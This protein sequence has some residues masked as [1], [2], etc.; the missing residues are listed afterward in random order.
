MSKLLLIIGLK[1]LKNLLIRIKGLEGNS[2]VTIEWNL[3]GLKRRRGAGIT[4]TEGSHN[5]SSK[6]GDPHLRHGANQLRSLN[7]PLL[8]QLA[9]PMEK[10]LR[11][12]NWLKP[13][14]NQDPR[15]MNDIV[16]QEAS[17]AARPKCLSLD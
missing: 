12:W 1:K 6:K 9:G 17:L 11:L 7:H 8:I 10:Q 14:R 4:R 2:R 3:R 5:S 15:Q 13:S 16:S